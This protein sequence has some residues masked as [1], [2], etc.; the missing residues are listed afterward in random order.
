MSGPTDTTLLIYAILAISVCGALTD[1]VCGKIFNWLTLPALVLGLAA[2]TWLNGWTGL[3]TAVL[4]TLAGLILYGWMFVLGAMGA[5]D[6]KFIMALG[7][8]GGV[9]FA[10]QTA[11]LGVLVGGLLA[12]LM[13]V[14]SGKM[15]G[16]LK[17]VHRFFLTLFVRE[18]EIEMPK[19][20]HAMTMPFGIP[21]AIAAAWVA[22]GDPFS[23]LGV[24]L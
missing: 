19:I 18:L 3:S 11:L 21:I 14:F 8:W 4:G 9:R 15:P 12:V 20:N 1:L 6:V 10:V 23:F 17:R 24:T 5:G 22:L 7:A 16:F 13:L 2:S